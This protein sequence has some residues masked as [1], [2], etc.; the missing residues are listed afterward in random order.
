MNNS[1]YTYRRAAAKKRSDRRRR[2]RQMTVKS[3]RI[4]VQFLYLPFLL[5]ALL[6]KL[7]MTRTEHEHISIT[8]Q[9]L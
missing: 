2:N 5:E 1:E 3:L 8:Q 4:Y 6:S 7:L 9:Y